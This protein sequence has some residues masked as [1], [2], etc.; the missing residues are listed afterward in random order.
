MVM[1]PKPTFPVCPV[2]VNDMAAEVAVCVLRVTVD[3]CWAVM[4]PSR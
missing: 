2:K 3:N 4:L 1:F